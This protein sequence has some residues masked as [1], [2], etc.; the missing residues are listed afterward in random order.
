M[1]SPS[2]IEEY[3]ECTWEHDAWQLEF[4]ELDKGFEQFL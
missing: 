4:Y 3:P 2:Y 1:F